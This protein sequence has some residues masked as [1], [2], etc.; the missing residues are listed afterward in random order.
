MSTA[1]SSTRRTET[2]ARRLPPVEWQEVACPLCGANDSSVVL[3]WREAELDAELRVVRCRHCDLVYTNPRPTPETIGRFYPNDYSCYELR[4]A[5]SR[6]WK[7]RLRARAQRL[8]LR[9]DF[10]YPPQPTD[11][12]ERL[13]ARLGRAWLRGGQRRSEWIP[14]RG[15]GKLL[16]FGCG[17]GAFLQRMRE[18]GWRVEGLDMSAVAA[19]TVMRG[20]DIKVHVGTLPH[21]DLTAESFDCITM[22]QALEHVHE[23]RLTVREAGRLLRPRGLLLIAVPNLASWSF[24]HFGRSWFGLDVPRHL[25]H[26]TPT[27]LN[28]LLAAEGFRVLKLTHI[29]TDGWLRQSARRLS[30]G[31]SGSIA[32]RACRWKPLAQAVAG[33]TERIGRA[34]DIIMLAERG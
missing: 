20:R 2:F 21:R 24:E 15:E 10:G 26:F 12:L 31:G 30:A 18:A 23:P 11:K 22:W 33:W 3:H 32:L 16:D 27:T 4:E 7:A 5:A 6:R 13:G 34:D 19:H 8:V 25:T 28:A 1:V 9:A 17:A 14:Y 29:G